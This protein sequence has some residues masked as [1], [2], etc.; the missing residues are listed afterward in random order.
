MNIRKIKLALTVGLL[1]QEAGNVVND[2]QAMMSDFREEVGA[3]VGAKVVKMAKLNPT[4]VQQTYALQ[5]ERCTLKVDLISN[6]STNL[7]VV[8]NFSLALSLIH[9]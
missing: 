6:P 7:Q 3:Y 5:Y 8:R 9:I 1:N 4:H 2:I